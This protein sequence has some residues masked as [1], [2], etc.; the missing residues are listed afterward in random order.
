MKHAIMIAAVRETWDVERGTLQLNMWNR[1]AIY[2]RRSHTIAFPL[3]RW[4]NKFAVTYEHIRTR[5]RYDLRDM[6]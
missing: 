3:D 5:T 4:R 6:R 2:R 1:M